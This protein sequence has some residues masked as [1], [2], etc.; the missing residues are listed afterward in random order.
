MPPPTGTIIFLFS[1]I[2]GSTRLWERHPRSMGEALRRHDAILR[3]AS[4]A[5]NGHVFKTIGDAFCIAFHGAAEAVSAAAIAQATLHTEAWNEAGPLKVRMAIHAGAAEARDNDYFGTSLNRVARILG[6]AHGGQVLL[7]LPARELLGDETPPGVDLRDLGERR[8]RDLSRPEHLFQL[9]MDALPSEF[10]PLRTLEATPNNLPVP[11]NSFIGRERERAEVKRRLSEG[12]LL[13]LMGTGGTGKTRLAIQAAEEM[14]GDFPDGVWLAEL[15]TLSDP[16]R[17]AEAIA[18]AAGL[19]EE[20]GESPRAALMRFL[21]GRR[22]LLILDNCEHLLEGCAALVS[23][24]LRCCSTMKILAT[25]RHSLGIAGE[26]A[27]PVP[28]LAA[29]DPR[30]DSMR[31]GP[32]AIARFESVRLF[33]ERAAAVKPGF[34]VTAANAEA[35]ARICWRLDG[36]PL[37]LELAAA[38]VRVL[39]PQQIADRLGDRFKLL[40]G[41]SRSGLPHQQTLR[42]LIDWSHDL[43]GEPERILFRRLAV[44]AGGRSLEALESVCVGN[45]IE[46]DSVLDLLQSLADKSLIT[47]E[48]DAADAVRYTLIESVWHYAAERLAAAGEEPALR[49][50]H[51]D[52]FLQFAEAARP[53]LEGVDAPAWLDRIDADRL[54]FRRAIKWATRSPDRVQK[55]LRIAGALARYLEIRGSFVEARDLYDTLLDAPGAEA[56]TPARAEAL[57]G[58]GRMAWGGEDLVEAA[59]RYGAAVELLRQLGQ[60]RDAIR[61]E[62]MLAFVACDAGRIDDVEATFQR[63]MESGRELRDVRLIAVGLSG[64]ARYALLRGDVARSRRLREESLAIYRVTGDEWVSGY[65][66]WGIARACIADADAPAARGA[67]EEWASIAR[68]LGNRWSLPFQLHLFAEVRLLE[69]NPADAA[70]LL[71]AAEAGRE[72]LGMVLGNEDRGEWE[73]TVARIAAKLDPDTQGR[74]WTHGRRTGIW[75]AVDAAVHAG[76]LNSLAA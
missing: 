2:E 13:T 56:P 68:K 50:L 76:P 18:V 33:A 61:E 66:L 11:L 1:D 4:D 36:I 24:M 43:L 63:T 71:G 32:L 40:A 25:S 5:H 22:V 53:A 57:A 34:T 15:A 65:L 58:A 42:M 19:R 20:S 30:G 54:N 44:F 59:R 28:P 23:E 52:Y 73:A 14:L 39:T 35:I 75:E 41:G 55:G 9:A 16:D 12:R 46:P 67:L 21:C 8:L 74:E 72:H 48:T 10:P 17:I 29:P 64:L 6:A 49:D 51:L 62:A 70:R 31:D 26:Q 3:A 38:R 45:G 7:S 60:T 69:G 47:V 37:A 27:W